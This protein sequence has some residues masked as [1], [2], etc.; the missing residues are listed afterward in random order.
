MKVKNYSLKV[1]NKVLLDQTDIS[2]DSGCFNHL[3]GKNGVGKSQFAKDFIINKGKY[4]SKDIPDR[5]LIISSYSNVPDELT[6]NDYL[7][8]FPITYKSEIKNMLNLDNIDP[9]IKI[10]KLSDGQKQKVKLFILLSFDK[11]IIILD[12]ITNALDKKT[13]IEIYQFF[14]EYCKK[15]KK[16]TIINISHNI[17]DMKNMPGN[18][19]VLENQ[20]INRMKDIQEAINWYMEA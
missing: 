4:F 10:K 17:A 20:K 14:K 11:D 7:S 2:F 15:Y 8:I 9:N 16:K 18:Y 19:Y 1:G 12:E 5:T 3:L 6:L 13:S